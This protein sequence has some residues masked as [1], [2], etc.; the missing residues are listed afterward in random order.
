[1]VLNDDISLD[2]KNSDHIARC[3]GVYEERQLCIKV[4]VYWYMDTVKKNLSRCSLR[5]KEIYI[6]IH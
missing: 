2:V 5:L 6:S 4:C 1:M 3:R